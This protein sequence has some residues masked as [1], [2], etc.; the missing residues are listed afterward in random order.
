[1]SEYVNLDV[2]IFHQSDRT[3]EQVADKALNVL[4]DAFVLEC[5]GDVEVE[6]LESA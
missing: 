4:A 6:I 1:M 5:G 3:P 2:R